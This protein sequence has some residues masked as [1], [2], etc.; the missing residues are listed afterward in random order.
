[1]QRSKGR[2]LD[3]A[4]VM[5]RHHCQRGCAGAAYHVTST[6]HAAPTLI[7]IR[8]AEGGGPSE[9]G[10]E[11]SGW[12]KKAR[13]EGRGQSDLVIAGDLGV[14][15]V[16]YHLGG[17][18]WYSAFRG[19]EAAVIGGLGYAD[20]RQ[21]H[22]PRHSSVLSRYFSSTT[23]PEEPKPKNYEHYYPK[24]KAEEEGRP[25]AA[26]QTPG[27]KPQASGPQQES[28]TAGGA[29]GAGGG[30][31]DGKKADSSSGGS[32]EGK[33]KGQNFWDEAF[34]KDFQNSLYPLLSAAFFLSLT[35]M[36]TSDASSEAVEIS[37]QEFKNELLEKGL[38]AKVEIVNRT[39]AKVEQMAAYRYYFQIGSVDSFER[40]LDDAQNAM[41]IDGHNR[42]PV[43][44]ASEVSWQQELLRLLPTAL[45]I[46]AWIYF[47]RGLQSGF[48]MGGMGGPGGTGGAKG[49][50]NVGKAAVTKMDKHS[51]NKVYFK[52][53]AG[54]DEAK[55][56]VMEFVHFLKNPA[57]YQALGAK[58]PRGALL[59]GP[60]GTGKTLLAKATAGEADVPFLSIS[61]SDFMEMFV[62]VGPSRVRDLFAQARACSPSIIFID[63]IDAVGRARGRGGFAGGNDERENTLNQ[64]LVEM[65]G[66]TTTSGVVVLAG[67]NRPDILDPALLRPGRFD[68]Q[69]TIDRPDI[70]GREQ[71]F[72]IYLSRVR[73]D[74]EV[75]FYSQRMA[76]LTPGFAG[77][78]IANVV[79]EAALMAARNDREVILMQ[80]F[81][82]AVDR[83]IG[84]LEKKGKVISAT[85]R[86]TVA[87]HEAGHAVVAWF[88]QHTEPLLKV[89]IVPRGTAA[90]GFAQYL[91]NENLLM[92]KDQLI[93]MTCMALG[94]R[95]AEQVLLGSVST[96]AQNDLERVTKTTYNRV[97]VYGFSDKLGLLSFPKATNSEGLEGLS[98][99]Y[100]NETADLI[101][102]EVREAVDSAYRRTL[103][104][105]EKH[106]GGVAAV[107]EELLVKEV[108][109]QEDLCQCTSDSSVYELGV[110]GKLMT[111]HHYGEWWCNVL[112]CGML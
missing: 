69:I 66:F 65:D 2:W 34:P 31:G 33:K 94:G 39:K 29:G 38:V 87:Y 18:R 36:L 47:S 93:D 13:T 72:R 81:E 37:F 70:K 41:G 80:D 78:D 51:K 63:E 30:E 48:G 88:L 43:T 42:I 5:T 102:T 64:L 97:A 7:D 74:K 86:R 1:M 52:D 44:Y 9:I 112:L 82:A 12:G 59:V 6:P 71:I 111:V 98:K 62:G 40:K 16:P 45:I 32:E 27:E 68:R 76:A 106:R 17:R 96:G 61:G 58:I 109:H 11:M 90:L 25:A 77:A 56:E 14:A 24:R 35:S 103:E 92:T 23:P 19:M 99:P 57:K 91:P 73:L 75:E 26:A 55:Q 89:S 110:W 105:M 85:E 104:L 84:G 100:S 49:I 107:A 15:V 28:A 95:A 21:V 20:S 67:T 8:E 10:S 108:L 50:F 54:C 79:N 60:P 101:D 4:R 53:V 22:I 3:A 83:V 46:A